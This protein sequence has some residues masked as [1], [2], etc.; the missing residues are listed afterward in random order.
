MDK[1]KSMSPLQKVQTV[2]Q[3]LPTLT[4]NYIERIVSYIEEEELVAT[5]SLT[6]FI[7]EEI[8]FKTT[9]SIAW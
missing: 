4:K 2:L 1:I 8:V 9:C 5:P 3:I 6:E 7:E